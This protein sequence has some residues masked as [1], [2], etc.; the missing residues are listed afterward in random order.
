MAI[1]AS[2]AS[3]GRGQVIDLTG[4][5]DEEGDAV[6][7]DR[8]PLWPLSMGPPNGST[9]L[10][11]GQHPRTRP[12]AFSPT[13][14]PNTPSSKNIGT[15]LSS[16][17][18]ALQPRPSQSLPSIHSPAVHERP[19]KRRK[20]QGSASIKAASPAADTK[21][22][23]KCLQSQV[24][25]H[26]ERAV[27]G[28][29]RDVYDV[30][31]LGGRVIGKIA[32]N[33]FERHFHNGGGRLPP[34]VEAFI[35]VRVHELVTEFIKG[36]EF[37][38]PL[39]TPKTEASPVPGLTIR[40]TASVLP[41]IE[42]GAGGLLPGR[43]DNNEEDDVG[44]EILWASDYPDDDD[45]VEDVDEHLDND[46]VESRHI[47]T[48]PPKPKKKPPITPQQ[49]RI[50]RKAT[51][52]QSGKS[53]EFK[54]E[55]S[56]PQVKSHW[57]GL[58]SR[59]YLPAKARQQI[60][61]GVGTGRLVHLHPDDLHQPNVYHVDFSDEEVRYLRRL[62]RFLR[63]KR[64]GKTARTDVEDLRHLMRKVGDT[65]TRILDAHREGYTHFQQPPSSLLK[66]S[67]D[68][69][70]NF[71]DDLYSR[72]ISPERRSLYIERDDPDTQSNFLRSNP[73]P[74]LLLAR[75]I[76]GNRLGATRSYQNFT[77]TFKSNREDYMEPKV[78]WT[79]CA[80]DIMTF[81]WLGDGG[82]F[83]VGTTTHSDSHNQQYNKPGNLLFGSTSSNKLE[84]YPHHRIPRPLVEHG[85]NALDSMRESQDP[86]LYTSVVDSDYDPVN[87]FAFTS[88]FDH[89]VKVWVPWKEEPWTTW[90]HEGRVNFVLTNKHKDGSRIATAADVPTGAVRV[91]HPDW[92]GNTLNTFTHVEYSCKRIH[93]EDYVPSDKWAYFPSAIRW[94]IEPST[95][96]LL[97]IGYSPR[98]LSG[99]D[100]EIPEDKRDTGELCIWDTNTNTEVKVNSAAT[101]NVFEVAWHPSRPS[102]AVATSAAQTSEKIEEHIRTQIRIFEINEAGQYAAIK[103]L[104]CPA[105]DINELLIRPNS[106]LYSYVAAG[107]TDGRVYVWDS[108]KSDDPICVLEHGDPV[109]E[110]IGDREHEDVGVK[111]V[112]W[113][114]TADRLYTG[115][116]DGVVKVWNIQHGKGVLVRDIIEVPGPI[117]AGAFSPDFTKLL[118]G[119]GSGRVYLMDLEDEDE[120]DQSGSAVVSSG[121]LKLQLGGKQQAIRRPRPFIPHPEVPPPEAYLHP[122]K[123]YDHDEQS[124]EYWLKNN[125]NAYG[126]GQRKAKE[127]LDASQLTL[128]PDPIVGAVQGPAYSQTGL[129]RAEAHLNEDVDGP[130]LS[131]FETRQ[132][133][134]QSFSRTSRIRR[135]CERTVLATFWTAHVRN[136]CIDTG[137]GV[138]DPETR[139]QLAAERAEVEISPLDSELDYEED[140]A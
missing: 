74:S 65:K 100:Y 104:D 31:K 117:T 79:N 108:A 26:L 30:E 36:N 17:Q 11:N 78:E 107:C 38:R 132:R 23:T 41:S 18:P 27:K 58:S 67:A 70:G 64:S 133:T 136:K 90:P 33:T 116:S 39:V 19:P 44:G 59:P 8:P 42:N 56:P 95:I 93:G 54:R 97:L 119:D 103:T 25:P 37:R 134:N 113:G 73:V 86:W 110:L 106:L 124:T 32:D 80:G 109:E 43:E 20:L 123:W 118:I 69:V 127:Y 4:S 21:T 68:D 14:A 88:S 85:D 40:S 81:S 137:I 1:N 72:Q 112:A 52:W 28:L 63:G 82:R 83:I 89:T 5:D 84:A 102:F 114:T 138:F 22:L 75:E 57:F 13:K 35:I 3:K 131:G 10:T 2:R 71:L 122:D 111:F 77:T 16:S 99:D 129:Y 48:P 55:G 53:Y 98:S 105:I 66:R 125:E 9:N 49:L 60:T 7:I 87:G 46:E 29:D 135:Q 34:D 76:T 130:L 50:K 120:R 51:Q 115:S 128:H 96:H 15:R 45:N 24:F 92:D 12:R 121:F 6:T 62:A 61:A 94:G 47:Q 140:E 126:A 101:C 91:Y 139:S